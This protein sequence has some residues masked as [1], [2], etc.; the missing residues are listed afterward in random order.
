MG[1]RAPAHDHGVGLVG[2]GGVEDLLEAAVGNDGVCLDGDAERLRVFLCLVEDGV[3]V[4][5]VFVEVISV[6]TGR[7]SLRH[8]RSAAKISSAYS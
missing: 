7:S 1:V 2:A 3:V 6:S 8:P 5:L 4:F